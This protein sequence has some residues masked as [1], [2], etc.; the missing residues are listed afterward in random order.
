MT[1]IVM[2]FTIDR[3]A[4]TVSTIINSIPPSVS[5]AR[6]SPLSLY[7][8]LFKPKMPNTMAATENGKHR[9]GSTETAAINITALA[10]DTMPGHEVLCFSGFAV[11]NSFSSALCSSCGMRRS[12]NAFL[13]WYA[14]VDDEVMGC[15][16]VTGKAA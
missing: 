10:S 14:G 2:L 9:T 5:P 16:A 4:N 11:L 12:E 13:A 7:R 6:A 15:L 1:L 3:I 8:F